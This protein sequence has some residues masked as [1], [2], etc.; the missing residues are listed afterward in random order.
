MNASETDGR[1]I[2]ATSF[3]AAGELYDQVRPGYPPAALEWALA[4]LGKGPWR[5]ADLGA[6]TGIMTRLVVATGHDAVAVE[7]DPQMRQRLIDT[8]TGVTVLAGS[9]E[10]IPLEAGS[11]D[12]AV[13]AQSYRGP[14]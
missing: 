8:T 3:G 11:I 4:P 10:S 14:T 2:R 5:V 6:G 13:A 9:A 7:P 1:R 12:G